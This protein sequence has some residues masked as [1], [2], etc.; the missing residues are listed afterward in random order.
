MLLLRMSVRSVSNCSSNIL[1]IGF[2]E[3]IAEAQVLAEKSGL[4]VDTL[5]QLIGDAFGPVAGGYSKRSVRLL[6]MRR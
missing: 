3:I 6:Y 1:T 5:D 4:G 2:M